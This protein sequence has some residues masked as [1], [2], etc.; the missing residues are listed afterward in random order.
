MEMYELKSTVSMASSSTCMYVSVD[1]HYNE[2]FSPNPLVYLDPVKTSVRDMDFGGFTYKEFLLW[3]TEFTKG[4][5]DNVYY[6]IRK[7][8]L[9]EGIRRIDSD[10]DYWEFMETV[11]SLKSV[12]LES[13]LDVYID[14]RNEPILD[15]ADNELLA[16]GKGYESD[17][18][19]KKDNKDSE[20]SETMAYKHECDEEVHTFD[21]IV[22][23]PFLDKLSGHISDDEE[24]EANNGKYKDVVFPVHNENQEW[25]QMVLVLGMKFSN[26]LELK[27]CITNYAVKNGYDLWYEKSDH[28]RLLVKCCKGKTNK[29]DKG[30]PFRLWATWMISEK[31]FQIKSLNGRHNC[32]RVFKFGS[33]VTYKW[34]DNHFMNRILQKPKM[35][36]RKLKAKVSKKFNLIASE[37]E[38]SLKEHYAK[39]WSYGEEIK[40]DKIWINTEDGYRCHDGW[41]EGCT[42]VIGLDGCFLKGIC[43]GRDANSHIYPISWVVVSVE[44]KETW[45]CF[46]DL[47]IKDLGVG[48]GHGLTLVSDQHKAVKE[49]VPAA[50]H[51]QCARHICAN[52]MKSFKGQLFRKLF[53]YASASTTPA[54]FEQH[55]NEINKLEPLAY[56]HLM[57]RDPKT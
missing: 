18:L 4:A 21:K 10:A 57:E 40:R 12:N 32:A 34:I 6:C 43:K 30:C 7:E 42:G 25:E 39:T 48:V 27:S 53:W 41:I 36:I 54:K 44:S 29:Q 13:E 31:S 46:I 11:Y 50:E 24:E 37:I 26:P 45:K 9:C 28:Q 56:D 16:Y 49:R 3:L 8:S 35:S 23:D 38:S 55:M 52:F 22:G 2:M 47:L 1:F 15:W 5:C 19:D 17:E 51:R 14:H 20:L 33:I